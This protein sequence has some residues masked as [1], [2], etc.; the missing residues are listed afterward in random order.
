MTEGE[1]FNVLKDLP[2]LDSIRF[3]LPV[4]SG[5]RKQG[6]IKVSCV[7][8]HEWTYYFILFIFKNNFCGHNAFISQV[9]TQT[10]NIKSSKHSSI[11]MFSLKT[12]HPGGIRTP[13]SCS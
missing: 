7:S 4:P 3:Q 5:F 6:K 8:S 11:A 12:V 2:Q 13:V 1:R 10:M 9:S